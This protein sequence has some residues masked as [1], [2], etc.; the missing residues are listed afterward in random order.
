MGVGTYLVGRE[1][2]ALDSGAGQALGEEMLQTLWEFSEGR[3]SSF[4]SETVVSDDAG[5]RSWQ[6]APMDED[7]EEEVCRGRLGR[8][9]GRMV[10][11]NVGGRH[12]GGAA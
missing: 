5:M 6:G 1:D 12:I 2:D 3:V 9:V 4:E 11:I 8:G 7:Q 10:G